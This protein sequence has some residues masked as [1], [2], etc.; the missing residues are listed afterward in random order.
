MPITF[1]QFLQLFDPCL[2]FFSRRLI[3]FHQTHEHTE[4]QS[5]ENL[6]FGFCCHAFP[7]ITY[8]ESL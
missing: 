4:H 8:T 1:V 6:H 7:S 3:L 5:A 2:I